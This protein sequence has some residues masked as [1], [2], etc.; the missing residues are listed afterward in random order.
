LR[1]GYDAREIE[2]YLGDE[3]GR[4][5]R[6]VLREEAKTRRLS[7]GRVRSVPW[8]RLPPEI[9]EQIGALEDDEAAFIVYRRDRRPWT[10]TPS[11]PLSLC[12]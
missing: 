1:I 6:F 11:E 10:A 2:A 8:D 4:Y 5:L 3:V 7:E 12:E 9:Q